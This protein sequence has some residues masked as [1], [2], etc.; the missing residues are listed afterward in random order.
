[1]TNQMFGD[2]SVMMAGAGANLR[3]RGYRWAGEFA[4]DAL[5]GSYLDGKVR[6]SSFPFQASALL[7]LIPEGVFNLYLLGGFRVQATHVDLDLSNLHR[8]QTFAEFG[9]HGGAGAD[10]NLGQRFALTADLRFFGLFR[11]DSAPAG[12]YYQGPEGEFG[13]VTDKSMGLQLNIGAAFRF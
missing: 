9:L 2:D 3:V 7:Y 5:G 8:G 13:I 11:D 6:R 1:M 10:L 4:F 12:R